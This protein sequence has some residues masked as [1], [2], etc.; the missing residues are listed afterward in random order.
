[1]GSDLR[2]VGEATNGSLHHRQPQ[3]PDVRVEGVPLATDALRRHVGHRAH[4]PRTARPEISIKAVS[5][6]FSDAARYGMKGDPVPTV[7][8]L[9]QLSM[10]TGMESAVARSC[11]VVQPALQCRHRCLNLRV[12]RSAPP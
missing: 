2:R 7:I 5:S 3:R 1:M 8:L 6:S 9:A 11:T 4:L 10:R 12:W